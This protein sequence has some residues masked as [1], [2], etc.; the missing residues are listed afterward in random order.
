MRNES[1]GPFIDIYR[2]LLW[3]LMEQLGINDSIQRKVMVAVTLQFFAAL[4][5][6]FIP[7]V[8]MGPMT[9]IELFGTGQVVATIIVFLL[10]L[11]AYVNTIWIIHRDIIEPIEDLR[12]ITEN[13]AQ[14]LFDTRPIQQTMPDE[15]G[16]LIAATNELQD[17][18]DTTVE[19]ARVLGKEQFEAPVLSDPVPG[20]FGTALST[21]QERLRNRIVSLR[22]FQA[23]VDNADHVI[24][25]TDADG[26]I[27]YVN[28][29]Y[30]HVT[31]QS[32]HDIIGTHLTEET[33]TIGEGDVAEAIWESLTSG[34]SITAE[35]TRYGS[36]GAQHVLQQTFVPI[37]DTDETHIGYAAIGEDVTERQERT[38][39]ISIFDRVLRHNLRNE[40]NIIAANA[41]QIRVS[42]DESVIANVDTILDVAQGLQETAEKGREVIKLLSERKN[43]Q[44]VDLTDVVTEHAEAVREIDES[45]DISVAMPEGSTVYAIEDISRA[46]SELIG[47]AVEHNDRDQPTVEVCAD[48]SEN[49][50][51][52][53]VRDDGPTIPAM[54][55]DILTGDIDMTSTS[56]GSG[57]GLWLVYWIV[58]RSNGK[59]SYSQ[60]EHG[61]ISS[62]FHSRMLRVIP[63]LL[64]G[65]LR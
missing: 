6:F 28:H 65:L 39:Q 63:R 38:R 14:G 62:Q 7:P 15:I 25:I 1:F 8:F 32:R 23:T 45:A 20:E 30:R 13:L 33:V 61:V 24:L 27:D 50:V 26:Y 16:N 64:M 5:L 56:H 47:N 54:E 10:L 41:E 17:Y 49:W 19:Q 53:H 46:V 2:R 58:H 37:T 3:G 35:L 18:L 21:M 12:E 34:D 40:L 11:I 44:R 55:R 51:H 52:L 48:T 36:E 31:G 42:G 4:A 29:Q 22:K 57:L 60:N 43:Q 9:V 59:L